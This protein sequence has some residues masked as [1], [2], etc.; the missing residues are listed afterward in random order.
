MFDRRG[1]DRARIGTSLLLLLA[2][3]AAVLACNPTPSPAATSTGP[4]D[5]PTPGATVAVSEPAGSGDPPSTPVE[6]A[7]A[8]SPACEP[9]DLKASHGLVEGA[10]GSRLTTVVL[11]AAIACSVDAF[12][13]LGLRDAQGTIL[14]G[15]AAAGPG[16]IDLVAGDAYE[17]NV[18]LANWCSGPPAFP[19]TLEIVMAGE[20]LAVTGSSF[21]EVG[22]LPPCSGETQGPILDATGWVAAP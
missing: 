20:E 15:A 6:T 12:P 4:G 9:A 13:A 21:P 22:D 16:R 1:H 5:A 8:G 19:L 10:A 2:L 17:S 3:A 18:R 7:T 11:T 14:V